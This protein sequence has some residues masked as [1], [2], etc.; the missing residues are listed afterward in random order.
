MKK[1]FV[2]LLMIVSVTVVAQT[3]QW[4]SEGEAYTYYGKILKDA[5]IK[6]SFQFTNDTLDVDIKKD[7]V[8]I[9]RSGTDTTYNELPDGN[10]DGKVIQLTMVA[11][12]SGAANYS[13]NLY[14]SDSIMLNGV[15]K[16]WRGMWNDS[17]WVTLETN[18]TLK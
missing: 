2:L 7:F 16:Y 3:P 11:Y 17:V 9:S 6:N 8:L 18:A 14:A 5:Q 12:A 10:I 1:L 13:A 4:T 15:G